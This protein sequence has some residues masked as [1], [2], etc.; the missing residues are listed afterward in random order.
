MRSAKGNSKNQTISQQEQGEAF[1]AYN[2][3][4]R[5]K[6]TPNKEEYPLIIKQ[7]HEHCGRI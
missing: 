1:R 5:S 2:N 6:A 4:T 7:I 3:T